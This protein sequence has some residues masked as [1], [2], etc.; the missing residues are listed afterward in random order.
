MNEIRSITPMFATLPI[1]A[2]R[3]FESAARLLS[4]KAAAAELA[5]TPAAV[6]HQ[7]RSLEDWLGIALFE[8]LP[9]GVRLTPSGERLF[10]SL[11]SALLDMTK[12]I[13]SVRPQRSAG[14]LVLSTTASF[15]ALWLIPRIGRFYDRNPGI[16]VRLDTAAAPIDL[17]QDASVDLVIRYGRTDYPDLRSHCRLEEI[18]GVYGSPNQVAASATAPPPLITVRWPNSTLYERSWQSWCDAAGENWLKEDAVLR[19]YDEEHYALQAAIGDQGLVLASSIM[20]SQ[21]VDSGLLVP[22]RPE[23]GVRGAAYSALCV[24]GRERHPPVRVF[25]EW[26][27]EEWFERIQPSR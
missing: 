3:T 11:H 22:Y 18:F 9:R 14:S 16:D 21:F 17:Y 6:S 20:V 24:P 25:L 13:D 4:F 15:A 12:V 26:L 1:T 2:L 8:R 23:I 10:H 27:K 7:V 19:E 5:V